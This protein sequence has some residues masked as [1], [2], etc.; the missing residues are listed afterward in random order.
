MKKEEVVY[1]EAR[2]VA[3]PNKIRYVKSDD[4]RIISESILLE[5]NT[6]TVDKS[7][8]YHS[9]VITVG[10]WYEKIRKDK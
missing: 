10:V 1:Y 6:Y 2:S 7:K 9:A 4:K 8:E 5:G 3:D